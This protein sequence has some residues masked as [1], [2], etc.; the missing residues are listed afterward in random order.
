MNFWNTVRIITD[1]SDLRFAAGYRSLFE[2]YGQNV[3]LLTV[4]TEEELRKA[5]QEPCSD[6]AIT[7]LCCHGW[8]K[9][10]EDAVLNWELQRRVNEIEWEPVEFHMTPQNV[11]DIVKTGHGILLNVACWGAKQSLADAFLAAGYQYYVAAEKTSDVFSAHQF[12]SAM[13]GYLLYEVRD[14][15][16]TEV[17][18]PEAVEMARRIDDFWDGANGFRVY[19]KTIEP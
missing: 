8:G 17:S 15:G 19:E 3:L 16:K 2:F 5:F 13:V 4:H 6:F 14:Y 1:K 7:M 10:E 12:V 18:V 9:T 11:R